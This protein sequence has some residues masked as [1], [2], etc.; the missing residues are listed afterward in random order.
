MIQP[1]TMKILDKLE[2]ATPHGQLPQCHLKMIT[3]RFI[4]G[5]I[6]WWLAQ[7]TNENKEREKDYLQS[8]AMSS[9]TQKTKEVGRTI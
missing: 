4:T 5:R 7:E 6:H 3:R 2:T 1:I 9:K 8:E